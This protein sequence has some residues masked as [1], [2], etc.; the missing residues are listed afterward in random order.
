MLQGLVKKELSTFPGAEAKRRTET[1]CGYH[2]RCWPGTVDSRMEPLELILPKDRE[3]RLQPAV[4]ESCLRNRRG[5]APPLMQMYVHGLS[6]RKARHLVHLLVGISTTAHRE[7]MTLGYNLKR[8]V[9]GA[10]ELRRARVVW[11]VRERK[12]RALFVSRL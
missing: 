3:V 11:A 2:N 5:L 10:L 12:R 8:Y 4:F 7:V 1:R 9:A 6:T